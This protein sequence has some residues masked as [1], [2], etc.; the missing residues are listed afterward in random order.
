MPPD[1][2]K[3]RCDNSAYTNA[4][5]ALA[6]SGPARMER[7]FKGEVTSDQ[8]SWEDI[9]KLIWMPFDETEGVMLE[10]EGYIDGTLLMQL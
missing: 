9:A 6:L 8:K 3:H 10:Y 7:L 4:A 5:A 1:E 2:Y